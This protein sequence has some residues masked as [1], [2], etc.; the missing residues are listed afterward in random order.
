MSQYTPSELN[1]LGSSALSLKKSM[2]DIWAMTHSYVRRD[3]FMCAPR[4]IHL[5]NKLKALGSSAPPLKQSMIDFDLIFS[6][7]IA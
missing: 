1:A 7:E 2:I 3:S 4:L 6:S 5:C